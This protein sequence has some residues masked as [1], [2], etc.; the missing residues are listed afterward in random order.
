MDRAT[1]DLVSIFI[2][3]LIPSHFAC[4]VTRNVD[5]LSDLYLEYTSMDGASLAL[6][7]NN[8][9]HSEKYFRLV[10]QNGVIGYLPTN[11]CNFLNTIRIYLSH[12]RIRLLGNISC[13]INLEEL[14]LNNNR[15][16]TIDDK[17]FTRLK[18]L[19]FLDISENRIKHLDP[20][21]VASPNLNIQYLNASYNEMTSLDITN[22]IMSGPFCERDFSSNKI[23]DLTN[24]LDQLLDPNNTYGPGMVYMNDNPFQRWPDFRKL[25]V[26]NLAML[27]KL[28][29]F[30]FDFRG[31]NFSCDCEM[32]P[33]LEI[34]E[35]VI[36]R[37]WVDFFHV[38][39]ASP[40][41]LQGEL[42][43]DLVKE[44]KL[45]LFVC[46]IDAENDCPVNCKCTEQ[47]SKSRFLVDCQGKGLRE[48]PRSL[49]D[50]SFEYELNVCYNVISVLDN[51]NYLGNIAVLKICNNPLQKVNDEAIKNLLN[52]RSVSLANNTDLIY[53][54]PKTIQYFPSHS[55]DLKNVILLCDCDTLWLS[56]WLEH[57]QTSSDSIFCETENHGRVNGIHLKGLLLKE[58]KELPSKIVIVCVC[59]ASVLILFGVTSYFCYNFKYE[60]A[61]LFRRHDDSICEFQYDIYISSDEGNDQLRAW[62]QLVLLPF[63][64]TFEYR[65]YFPVRDCM[66]SNIAEEECK[67]ILRTTRCFLVILSERYLCHEGRPR[68]EMEWKYAWDLYLNDKH[69]KIVMINFDHLSASL[70]RPRQ[71]KAFLRLGKVIDFGNRDGMHLFNMQ[72]AIGEPLNYAPIV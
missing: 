70:V 10:H 13:L 14:D 9:Y 39:C 19:L 41:N 58:C 37:T 71:I 15:L 11:I 30:G 6:T 49:P 29:D 60:L 69:R 40:P 8:S 42:I 1:F 12:N 61:I 53:Y 16:T 38:K 46:T 51:R 48:L 17:T 23:K 63:L 5:I 25:G 56:D 44:N 64:Q 26:Q 34:A 20:L 66:S 28:F 59:L 24:V 55:I 32:E 50:S 7:S 47:P 72:S 35:E 18:K 67:N 45:D 57:H 31:A 54:L 21:S 2:L 36:R 22:I 68:T 65:I 3:T 33:F 43:I 52:A 62:I 27:G 4:N